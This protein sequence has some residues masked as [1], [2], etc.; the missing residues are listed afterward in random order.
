MQ[1]FKRL[2]IYLQ[3]VMTFLENWVK[4]GYSRKYPH[5]PHW[6]KLTCSTICRKHGISVELA[7]NHEN[8][9]LIPYCGSFK[10][11]IIYA[12]TE[13]QLWNY[14][15]ICMELKVI[16]SYYGKIGNYR[17]TDFQ[18]NKFHTMEFI[19]IIPF[20]CTWVTYCG[21]TVEVKYVPHCFH[22]M[23]LT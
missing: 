10:F 14:S 13:Y 7:W 19:W 1:F 8:S 5:P 6:K 17:G 23:E 18:T 9:T 2:S 21:I 22:T 20:C 12:E 16:Q 15:V 11:H 3:F 4:M